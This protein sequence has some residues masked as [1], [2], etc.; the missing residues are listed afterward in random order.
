QFFESGILFAAFTTL[1]KGNQVARKAIVHLLAVGE[2]TCQLKRVGHGDLAPVEVDLRRRV[3][4]MGSVLSSEGT[5]R[6]V[7]LV[8]KTIRID[9]GGMA[10]AASAA[11]GLSVFFYE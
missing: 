11:L 8:G 2:G 7:M 5:N 9:Q 6:I 10:V 3:D 4:R 1:S